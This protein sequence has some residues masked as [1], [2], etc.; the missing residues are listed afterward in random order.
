MRMGPQHWHKTAAERDK[1]YAKI[2]TLEKPFHWQVD[3]HPVDDSPPTMVHGI[4]NT[5]LELTLV[6][7]G[8]H[9]HEVLGY[10]V[11][12]EKEKV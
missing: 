2:D 4:N 3:A 11:E 5:E 9:A 6:Y 10:I 1:A 8:E 7:V 12:A